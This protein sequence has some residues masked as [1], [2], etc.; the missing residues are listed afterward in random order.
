MIDFKSFF[1]HM[2]GKFIIAF[3][4]HFRQPESKEYLLYL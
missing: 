4:K 1:S 2:T 3:S